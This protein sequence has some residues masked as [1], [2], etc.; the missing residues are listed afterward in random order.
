LFREFIVWLVEAQKTFLTI[1]N[2][3]AI[4]YREVFPLIKENKIWLGNNYRVNGGA[5]YYEIPE[6]IAN[7]DQV[8]E[9]QTDDSGKKK[10]ITRVQG[11]RWFTNLDHGRRHEPLNL[12]TMAENLKFNK[13]IREVGY[14]KYENYDAIEVPRVE[15]IPSDHE[16]VMGV[17]ISFLD[18]YNPDQFEIVG[19]SQTM[20][21]ELGFRPIGQQFVDD[22]YRQGNKGQINAAWNYLVM[23]VGDQTVIPYKRILIRHKKASK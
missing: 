7:L 2:M 18:K 11:I 22:Y 5:M 20:A 1:G 15:A 21:K 4:T 8:R 3:N 6:S 17:P 13:L 9:I 23:K 19:D 14:R 16:G 12:M 10:F